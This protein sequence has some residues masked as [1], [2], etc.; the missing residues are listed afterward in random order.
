MDM[1]SPFCAQLGYPSTL[2]VECKPGLNI[3]LIGSDHALFVAESQGGTVI[4][5]AHV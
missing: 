2:R 1:I 4:G 3:S 5:W